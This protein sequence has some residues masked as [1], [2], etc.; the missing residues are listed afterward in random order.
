MVRGDEADSSKCLE[1]QYDMMVELTELA[2]RLEALYEREG[3]KK[4]YLGFCTEQLE[5]WNSCETGKTVG[6]AIW[7]REN[8]AW[9]VLL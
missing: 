7:V 9:R 1:V 8:R 2:D 3:K 5:E 4:W 6:E